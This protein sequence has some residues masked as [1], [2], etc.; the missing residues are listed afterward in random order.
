MKKRPFKR[1]KTYPFYDQDPLV[2]VT[3]ALLEDRK[4]AQVAKD[5][6]LSR[7]TLGNWKTK[8]TKRPQAA[9][10]S[11]AGGLVGKELVWSDKKKARS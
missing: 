8:K 2:G 6:G 11:A 10:L 7:T 5:T 4:F 1:Y 3:L 9:T